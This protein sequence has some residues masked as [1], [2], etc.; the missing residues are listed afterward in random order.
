MFNCDQY[1]EI[2][3]R[4]FAYWWSLSPVVAV[5]A[6]IAVAVLVGRLPTNRWLGLLTGGLAGGSTLVTAW[7]VILVLYNAAR[8]FHC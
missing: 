7:I 2:C 3:C 1:S 8:P 4:D 6:G 5:L